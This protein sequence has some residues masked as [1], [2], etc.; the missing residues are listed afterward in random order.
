[1]A[2]FSCPRILRDETNV[3]NAGTIAANDQ[4]A[5]YDYRLFCGYPARA[6]FSRTQLPA[7]HHALPGCVR[8]AALEGCSRR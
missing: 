6:A 8:A 3:R 5:A 1:M 7:G 4:N 2:A